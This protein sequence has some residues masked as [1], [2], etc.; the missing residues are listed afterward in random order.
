MASNFA[1][2]LSTTTFLLLTLFVVREV[3][4][5]SDNRKNQSLHVVLGYSTGHVG[6][7]TIG[8]ADKFKNDDNLLIQFECKF[9]GW[10][11]RSVAHL[12]LRCR[13]IGWFLIIHCP[14]GSLVR[15]F[16]RVVR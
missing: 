13:F 8:Y 1:T 15:L 4:A 11:G 12:L 7:T 2:L 10:L 9:V 3:S 6:T 14:I 5:S 16:V